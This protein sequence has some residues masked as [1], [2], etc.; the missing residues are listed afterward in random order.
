MR[1]LVPTVA[2]VATMLAAPTSA[3]AHASSGTLVS[4]G[5]VD[6]TV[7]GETTPW[8]YKIEEDYKGTVLA[9]GEVVVKNTGTLSIGFRDTDNN[10]HMVSATIFNNNPAKDGKSEQ[11]ATVVNCGPVVGTPGP[12]GPAGPEGPKGSNGTPGEEGSPGKERSSWR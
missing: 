6:F 1:K 10:A 11:Y 8:S 2:L 9:Q 4:C 12:E 5:E 3:L 7:S